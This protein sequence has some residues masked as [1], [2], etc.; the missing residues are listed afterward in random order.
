MKEAEILTITEIRELCNLVID[1][2]KAAAVEDCEDFDEKELRSI[3]KVLTTLRNRPVTRSTRR[4]PT[5]KWKL[6][7]K[8]FIDAC[9]G[10]LA[11]SLKLLINF[12]AMVI[13]KADHRFL[14]FRY[15]KL[16]LREA[17]LL[18]SLGAPWTK[19]GD[20]ER[21]GGVIRADSPYLYCLQIMN[22]IP[23]TLERTRQLIMED[24]QTARA[25]YSLFQGVAYRDEPFWSHLYFKLEELGVKPNYTPEAKKKVL[26]TFRADNAWQEN[27][28]K[29]TMNAY[30]GNN[31]AVLRD[32]EPL[33]KDKMLQC[34]REQLD[35]MPRHK[36]KKSRFETFWESVMLPPQTPGNPPYDD[37]SSDW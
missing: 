17:A 24:E 22:G 6:C 11:F 13:L 31:R 4:K 25:L 12:F 3:E 26:A 14:D 23:E 15:E 10:P 35:A 1:N 7:N 37:R 16:P 5:L 28:I 9:L 32:V 2:W 8:R 21:Y 18:E 29:R 34:E 27:S 20:Y 33:L 19:I 36:Q 30:F